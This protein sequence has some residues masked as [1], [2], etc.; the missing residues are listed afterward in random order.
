VLNDLSGLDR[1]EHTDSHRL[2]AAV[3][4]FKARLQGAEDEEKK[5]A[6]LFNSENGEDS[7]LSMQ[8]NA[9]DQQQKLMEGDE[10]KH[11]QELATA[12]QRQQDV[13]NVQ[14]IH[15][16]AMMKLAK[17][18]FQ[19]V[20]YLEGV[21][22]KVVSGESE[23]KN[24]KERMHGIETGI[25]GMES[26]QKAGQNNLARL[27]AAESHMGQNIFGIQQRAIHDHSALQLEREAQRHVQKASDNVYKQEHDNMHRVDQ[28][29]H[30]VS[31]GYGNGYGNMAAYQSRIRSLNGDLQVMQSDMASTGT[32][33]SAARR[34][35]KQ[36]ADQIRGDLAHDQRELMRTAKRGAELDNT[37][38]TEERFE[39]TYSASAADETN[40][41]HDDEKRLEE[42]AKKAAWM[43]KHADGL[44]L[45]GLTNGITALKQKEDSAVE[46]AKNY[47]RGVDQSRKRAEAIHKAEAV[48]GKDLDEM[49]TD[50]ATISKEIRNLGRDED[51][52]EDHL[53]P[54][55]ADL[56][57]AKN[58][59]N[60]K[61]QQLSQ[62]VQGSGI[63]AQV[64]TLS[65]E[66]NSK[67]E[68][69]GSLNNGLKN[70][71][72]VMMKVEHKNDQS[73]S[74]DE[75]LE[76][77][78]KRLKENVDAIE[79]QAQQAA[80]NIHILAGG[81]LVFVLASAALHNMWR[82]KIEEL[83]KNLVA[84]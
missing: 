14:N 22:G 70:E 6:I 36:D 42:E 62:K 3:N 45:G 49:R 83:D 31:G 60:G 4:G 32:Q 21:A 75:T 59:F 18:Q 41:L 26:T 37:I 13:M 1:Q 10:V 53:Q 81:L 8:V 80:T 7:H 57:E 51:A 73:K 84:S 58:T 77:H 25:V 12:A 67:Q 52:F 30:D 40:Q 55:A 11:R 61:L 65:T 50:N 72:K 38:H 46:M 71:D 54:L 23:L 34:K 47:Q 17:V 68:E 16:Q 27:D 82:G 43:R 29:E 5:D 69:V 35:Q 48:A 63:D 44:D 64:Q 76:D 24:L 74:M 78:Q 19:S 39:N 2:A 33:I 20:H 56:Q 66:Q 15:R 9:L 79:A 28:M